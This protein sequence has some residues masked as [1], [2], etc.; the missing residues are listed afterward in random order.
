MAGKYKNSSQLCPLKDK[1]KI[2][3]VSMNKNEV[4]EIINKIKGMED[5]TEKNLKPED[6]AVPGGL[7]EKIAKGS[8]I[9]TAQ[10][11]KFFNEIKRLHQITKSKKDIE[12]IKLPLI[13]LIP[14]LIFAKN[15]D[16]ISDEFY[17][18]LE[19][20]ILKKKE[21]G[22]ME[23]RFKSYEEFENFVSFLEAI[24]AYQKGG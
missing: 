8:K 19:A 12:E 4:N 14:Q 2:K 6:Y 21:N 18:L 1:K 15:R 17:N 20:C 24:V 22:K 9:K 5:L 23:C 3:E 11:R 7:A 13:K 16:V 10:L